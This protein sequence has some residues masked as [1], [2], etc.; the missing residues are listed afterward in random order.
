MVQNTFEKDFMAND[1]KNSTLP[2]S[3]LSYSSLYSSLLSSMLHLASSWAT[4]S[5][6]TGFLLV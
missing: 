6:N 1:V 5:R 3:A 4:D 2:L